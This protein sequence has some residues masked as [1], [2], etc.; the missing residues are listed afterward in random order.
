MTSTFGLPHII[1][2]IVSI[3]IIIGGGIYAQSLSKRNGKLRPIHAAKIL[4][5]WGILNFLTWGMAGYASGDQFLESG[6]G[7][8]KIIV[9]AIPGIIKAML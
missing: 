1:A 3:F 2:F 8:F 9:K 5:I 4:G 7:S 6:L